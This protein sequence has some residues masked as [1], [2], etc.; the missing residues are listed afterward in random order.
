[1]NAAALS[2]DPVEGKRIYPLLLLSIIPVKYWSWSG[3]GAFILDV[4]ALR[5]RTPIVNSQFMILDYWLALTL[6][7]G[8]TGKGFTPETGWRIP[9]F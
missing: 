4:V 9:A 3:V 5:A 8:F 6:P 1:L 7:R 2:L